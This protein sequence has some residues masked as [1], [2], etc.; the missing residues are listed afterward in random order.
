VARGRVDDRSPQIAARSLGAGRRIDQH[1]VRGRG[2]IGRSA[3]GRLATTS[4]P[5]HEAKYVPPSDVS[6]R[7][8]AS[9]TCHT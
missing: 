9:P 5:S 7:A 6:R 8:V 4:A 2:A 3:P 1:G